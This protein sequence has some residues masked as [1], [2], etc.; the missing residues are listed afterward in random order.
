MKK[1]ITFEGFKELK[2]HTTLGR[3]NF[4]S[5]YNPIELG[6]CTLAIEFDDID[7]SSELRALYFSSDRAS[8]TLYNVKKIIYDT[9]G[10]MDILVV[11]GD[12]HNDK[13]DTTYRFCLT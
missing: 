6:A 12:L 9:T 11:C 13:N 8:M 10:F 1:Y 3:V 2:E 5:D 7:Y 4:L